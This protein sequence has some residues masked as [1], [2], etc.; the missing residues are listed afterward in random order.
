MKFV[1][2]SWVIMFSGYDYETDKRQRAV[3]MCLRMLNKM[4]NSI[5][6]THFMQ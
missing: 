3:E 5:S 6:L 1:R 2:K 4:L